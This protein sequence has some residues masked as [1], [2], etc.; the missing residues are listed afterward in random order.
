M[1]YIINL[2]VV[3][4]SLSL[5]VSFDYF[6]KQGNKEVS[7][8][9]TA[10]VN[11]SESSVNVDQLPQE[12]RNYIFKHMQGKE[13]ARVK[14]EEDE[15]KVWLSTGEQ[16]EFDID[17]NIKE[18]ECPAGITESEIDERVLRDVKTIDSQA[19][20]VKIEQKTNGDFD[21][22][23]NNGMEIEYDANFKRIGIED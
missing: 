6:K 10:A 7:N 23:L 18:I 13:I 19:V 3:I 15:F 4:A 16:L 12:A 1:R 9:S 11:R 5:V 22:K 20:I 17:G 8:H 14:A 2:I 21:V